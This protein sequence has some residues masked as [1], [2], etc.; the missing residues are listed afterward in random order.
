M[1]MITKLSYV[2]CNAGYACVRST[3]RLAR[4]TK[5]VASA[6]GVYAQLAARNTHDFVLRA[7][8]DVVGGV[9]AAKYEHYYKEA[10]RPLDR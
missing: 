2:V 4:S 10:I 6:T 3:K 8:C 1:S 5:H 7:K 9:H